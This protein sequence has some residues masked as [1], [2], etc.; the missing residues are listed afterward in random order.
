MLVPAEQTMER[1]LGKQRFHWETLEVLQRRH[2]QYR[3]LSRELGILVYDGARPSAE[4]AEAIKARIG[5]A[6]GVT[7]EHSP[8]C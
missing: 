6:L 3:D 7:R 2:G 1:S 4:I 5:D 8:S